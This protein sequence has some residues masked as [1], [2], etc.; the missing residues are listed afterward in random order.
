MKRKSGLGYYNA[1]K[2]EWKLAWRHARNCHRD[3]LTPDAS[4]TGIWWK[5]ILIASYERRSDVWWS[6]STA[7][8]LWI[9]KMTD[10]MIDELNSEGN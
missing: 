9:M 10:E 2:E 3:K 7:E 6:M 1:T 5:A 4:L 8:R